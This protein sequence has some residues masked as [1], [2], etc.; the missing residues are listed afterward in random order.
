MAVYEDRLKCG[1]I[2]IDKKLTEYEVAEKER[3][4][5]EIEELSHYKNI[6]LK[7]GRYR[8]DLKPKFDEVLGITLASSNQ[9][10]IKIS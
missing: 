8:T 6:I 4:Q 2:E 9:Y 5:G 10:G 7:C 1:Q 3:I